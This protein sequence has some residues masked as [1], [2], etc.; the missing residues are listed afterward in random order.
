MTDIKKPIVDMFEADQ[1]FADGPDGLIIRHDQEITPELL[2]HLADARH[3]S[4][5]SREGD[6]MHVAAIP[7]IIVEQWQRDG[8][9][10][11]NDR[12]ITASQIVARL[13]AENLTAFLAT[14]KRV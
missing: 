6:F 10:I 3:N 13:K 11:M 12:N 1:S 2:D 8:F 7:T 14:N 4:Q 9:D 5:H